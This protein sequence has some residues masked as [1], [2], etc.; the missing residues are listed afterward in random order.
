MAPDSLC[1]PPNR[2][3]GLPN[4]P[5]DEKQIGDELERSRYKTEET[6]HALRQGWSE[7]RRMTKQGPIVLRAE[8]HAERQL[9]SY[10]QFGRLN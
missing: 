8:M 9:W 3:L 5:P 4:V 6:P 1:M 2:R 10:P 7:L